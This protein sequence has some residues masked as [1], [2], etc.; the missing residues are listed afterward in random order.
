MTRR[1]PIRLALV[2]ALAASAFTL[3]SCSDD[4]D[5]TGPGGAIALSLSSTSATVAPGGQAVIVGT[6]TRSGGF[7]GNVTITVTGAPTGVTG[8]VGTVTTIG[9]VS[10]ATVTLAIAAG[11]TAGTYPITVKASGSGVSDVSTTYNLTVSANAQ[12]YTLSAAPTAVSIA[13]GA[14][15]TATININRSAFT[16][17][18]TLSVPTPPSGIT[19]TFAPNATTT[20]SSTATLNVAAGTATGLNTVTIKGVATGQSDQFVTVNVTVTAATGLGNAVANFS[21]CTG[22]SI[23]VWFAYQDGASG[24][25]TVATPT[26]NTYT[27]AVT[28]PKGAFA[29]VTQSTP[30]NF[31]T[32]VVYYTNTELTSAPFVFCTPAGTNSMSGTVAGL[33]AG[34]KANVSLGASAASTVFPATTFTLNTLPSGTF[35]LLGYRTGVTG[36]SATDKVIIRRNQLVANAGTIALLDFGA[37]EAATAAQGTITVT[38]DGGAALTAQMTYY[39]A[40]CTTNG[41]LYLMLAPVSPFTAYGVPASLQT[42]TDFHALFVGATAAGHTRGAIDV[43]HTMGN[44]TIALPTALP[45]PTI[46]SLGGNYKR[47]QAVVTLPADY[48]AGGSFTYFDGTG[49]HSVAITTTAGY[50]GGQAATIAMPSFTGLSGWLDTYAPASASAVTTNV[51][52]TGFTLTGSICQEGYRLVSDAVSGTN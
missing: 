45:A 5:T 13:A 48:N 8:T 38:N 9:T 2:A 31:Q 41:S 22:G 29:Y 40:N 49:A 51:N 4:N 1:N 21:T 30:G 14:S 15:G 17:A 7:T 37:G 23:P 43:F 33:S 6:V 26:N 47:L 12:S 34:Q 44:R 24:T 52:G 11:T 25:W 36:P 46:T 42:A 10:T 50:N 28:Q 18:V 27:F 35:D 39:T 32:N 20:N 16:G 19:A 3:S